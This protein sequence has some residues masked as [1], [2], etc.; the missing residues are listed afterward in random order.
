MDSWYAFCKLIKFDSKLETISKLILKTGKK[1]YLFR[2]QCANTEYTEST[3][4]KK[5]G[6]CMPVSERR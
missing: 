6:H 1:C 3:I 2:G 4:T 5:N